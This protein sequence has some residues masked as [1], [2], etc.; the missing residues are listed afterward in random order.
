MTGSDVAFLRS[1]IC[2]LG[3]TAGVEGEGKSCGPPL[4][5]SHVPVMTVFTRPSLHCVLKKKGTGATCSITGVGAVLV[6]SGA[7]PTYSVLQDDASI[8]KEPSLAGAGATHSI[9]GAGAEVAAQEAAGGSVW[10][11]ASMV[12]RVRC[13]VAQCKAAATA[14]LCRPEDEAAKS[15]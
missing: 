3:G 4:S 10:V 2:F 9:T 15:T 7:G 6:T 13:L 5:T 11:M 8:E 1:F 12:R 14:H